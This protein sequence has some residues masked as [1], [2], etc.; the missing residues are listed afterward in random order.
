MNKKSNQRFEQK[1][2][3]YRQ[4]DNKIRQIKKN[5]FDF[6]IRPRGIPA[7]YNTLEGYKEYLTIKKEAL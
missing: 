5:E 6:K 4:I 2:T 7:L 1:V 3:Y